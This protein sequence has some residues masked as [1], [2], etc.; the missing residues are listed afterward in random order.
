MTFHAGDRVRWVTTGD[1]G[2]P[3][4][5]YGFVGSIDGD[6]HARVML[7]DDLAGDAVVAVDE[8]ATVSITNVELRLQ[9]VD[10]LDD[11]SLRQGLV[12]L[13]WAEAEQAGLE[14]AAVEQLG[15]G[16]RLTDGFALADLWSGGRC[17][18]LRA[19]PAAGDRDVVRV[20]AA[21]KRR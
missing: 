10:L 15:T 1:D 11:P 3:L 9:G 16:V 14:L 21:P 19:C 8:L 18:V 5:R 6:G 13:W 17:Y 20:H 7:D 12:N 4:V 2:L